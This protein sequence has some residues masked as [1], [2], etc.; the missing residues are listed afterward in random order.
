[1]LEDLP[2]DIDGELSSTGSR[3]QTGNSALR[4]EDGGSACSRPGTSSNIREDEQPAGAQGKG[5]GSIAGSHSERNP[6][7]LVS[8]APPSRPGTSSSSKRN[9]NMWLVRREE[10]ELAVM[11]GLHQ[12]LGKK[13]PL[14]AVAS[15][16]PGIHL[17][18]LYGA[19]CVLDPETAAARAEERRLEEEER[20]AAQARRLKEEREAAAAAAAEEAA[21]LQAAARSGSRAGSH[22]SSRPGTG[23]SSRP[24]TGASAASAGGSRPRPGSSAGAASSM[25]GLSGSRM[26]EE[27]DE[28]YMCI[29]D[30]RWLAR[31]SED[32]VKRTC[33]VWCKRGSPDEVLYELR[34]QIAKKV[35][36]D[37]GW[38]GKLESTE[39]VTSRG[40][41]EMLKEIRVI[42]D[43]GRLFQSSPDKALEHAT[44]V[45]RWAKMNETSEEQSIQVMM[46][47]EMEILRKCADGLAE[48]EA[49]GIPALGDLWQRDLERSGVRP[50]DFGER[51]MPTLGPPARLAPA[52]V[53]HQLYSV[54]DDADRFGGDAARRALR[55][56]N[57][58]VDVGIKEARGVE[59]E[60]DEARKRLR[61][62]KKE[63]AQTEAHVTF[64]RGQFSHNA[65]VLGRLDDAEASLVLLRDKV[66][67]DQARLDRL[68]GRT[69]VRRIAAVE[70]NVKDRA[71]LIGLKQRVDEGY[72][73]LAGLAAEAAGCVSELHIRWDLHSRASS[74]A[75]QP[76][77][78]TASIRVWGLGFG[79]QMQP[80]R[81]GFRVWATNATA[82]IRV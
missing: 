19:D 36:R 2:E 1:M 18:M 47:R 23:A 5:E 78:A 56:C 79:L 30:K 73:Q 82:S 9:V 7:A 43:K 54:Y 60:I 59:E 58:G 38:G 46:Q 81:L 50:R 62:G 6:S 72:A 32:M 52:L 61:S 66:R 26:M 75:M 65:R 57:R 45:G 39:E 16:P 77:K 13:S 34:R 33:K 24:A 51:V 55:E 70:A 21:L 37:R 53:K 22:R 67:S 3:P 71:G 76:T 49:R 48:G 12:R 64:L 15:E 80:R 29:V 14:N 42:E 20:A 74:S 44:L 40:M 41:R 35:M 63:L 8:A 69:A 31:R 11:M 10:M 17:M 25:S 68:E 28:K 27:E 4:Q